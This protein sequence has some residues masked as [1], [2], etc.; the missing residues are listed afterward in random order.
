MLYP[1]WMSLVQI[2]Q[3]SP[4]V[5]VFVVAGFLGLVGLILLT[6]S[7]GRTLATERRLA[8]LAISTSGLTQAQ[9]EVLGQIKAMAATTATLQAA[10]TGTLNER[11]D[12]V[13]GQM[14]Q[15]LESTSLR[16][17]E[18]LGE[19]RKHLNKIDEAQRNITELSSQVVNLQDLLANKQARGA[20]GE[21][22]LNDIVR[23]ILP[24]SAYDLQK[25]LG[26]GMRPDC[27]IRLPNPPG[28]IA[29]DAK[30]PLESYQALRK[31]TNDA[32]RLVATRKFKADMQKHLRDIASRY[33]VPGETAE[34]AIMFI[35]SEAVYAE[36]HGYLAEVVD[37]SYRL[38]VWIV[39]PT[40]MWALL[41]TVRA[42]L[43][44]VQMR[45]QADVIQ[46]QV[47]LLLQDATRLDDRVAALERHFGQTVDDVRKIRI[48]T[49]KVL[50]RGERIGELQLE[51][52]GSPVGEDADELPLSAPPAPPPT[53]P[54]QQEAAG[55]LRLSGTLRP[56]D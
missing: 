56:H 38:R 10:V 12:A 24:P 30:F 46:A 45:E 40:T 49:D 42:V 25:A 7:R 32:E 9:G 23:N 17:A 19:L 34:S 52:D 47:G 28:P 15:S 2:I 41:N 6:R 13:S 37:E 5:P 16:T 14:R 50:R 27:L 43:K 8:E 18:S 53:K 20:F 22:Q 39:S 55:E 29:V 48:S 3:T 35:P 11:L 36:I 4:W 21:V 26:N 33:I 44:D 51:T 1:L 31:A 54:I